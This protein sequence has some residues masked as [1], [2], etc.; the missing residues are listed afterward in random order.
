MRDQLHAP[1]VYDR[2]AGG[3]RYTAD[4]DL[5]G[6]WFK[7]D[8]L[9]ALLL[10]H[11]LIDQLQPGF[12]QDQLKPFEAKLRALVEA[13]AGVQMLLSRVRMLGTP[14]R[15][16]DSV[17]FQAVCQA[18][19]ERRQIR[20]RYF[21]RGRGAEGERTLSPQKL[22]YY[23][24]NWYLDAWCHRNEAVQ[25]LSVDAMRGLRV[26]E[27]AAFEPPA[28]SEEGETT[29]YGI[30][31]G[32][33]R[34]LAVL[35]FD[36][37]A[38]RWVGEEEWH[39]KQRIVELPEGGIHLEVPYS[40]PQEIVMDILRHGPRVEVWVRR[41]C[42]ARLPRRTV[43]LPHSMPRRSARPEWPGARTILNPPVHSDCGNFPQGHS[44]SLPSRQ[45]TF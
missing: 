39:P 37:T 21:T 4:F 38:A 7:Q 34:E 40:H 16:V 18:T 29:G 15:P 3:Y 27:A 1:I 32:P 42:G 26:L 5:P 19:L 10:M 22:I 36:S 12:L 13:P 2:E 28:G 8:E 44:V 9:Y 35:R 41:R 23:R 30:F 11:G 20:V 43:R 17:R 6:L 25:R 31:G 14:L 33:A 45:S 24:G